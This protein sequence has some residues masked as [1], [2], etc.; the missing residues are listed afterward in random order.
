MRLE[1]IFE[2]EQLELPKENKSIWISFFKKC[3]TRCGNGQ[4]YDRYFG[5]TKQKDYTFSVIMPNPRFADEKILLDGHQIKLLFSSDDGN[6]TGLIFYQAFI[7]AKQK[8]FPLPEG[9]G[10]VLKRINQMREKLITSSRV[11]FRTVVGSGLVIRENNKETN[12]DKF[13]TF[14]DEGFE[15]QFKQVLGMQ[16]EEAGFPAE[17]GRN[18]IFKAVQCKKVLV[19]QYGIY[20]DT[21]IGIFEVEGDVDFLQYLYQAGMGSKHSMGYGML[22][23]VAQKM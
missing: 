9:N 14:M 6:K 19:K 16:A 21:T 15:N 12:R 23:I 11:M 22:D 7:S 1:L 2:I 8:R 4:F 13:F 18:L 5:G 3:L 20:V 10:L 17:A